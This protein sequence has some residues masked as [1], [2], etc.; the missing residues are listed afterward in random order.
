MTYT[1]RNWKEKV[2]AYTHAQASKIRGETTEVHINT[3]DNI[4][5]EQ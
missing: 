4:E 3:F 1:H 2:V 5:V